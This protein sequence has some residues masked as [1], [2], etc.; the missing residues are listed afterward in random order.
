MSVQGSIRTDPARRV[1]PKPRKA[2][3]AGHEFPTLGPSS[4][5]A[6]E[7]SKNVHFAT[8]PYARVIL[9]ERGVKPSGGPFHA[10]TMGTAFTA[11]GLN[12]SSWEKLWEVPFSASLSPVC[13]ACSRL[14][15]YGAA[16][17]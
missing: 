11:C 4:N 7:V 16:P 3:S 10:K 14:V 12:S 5:E 15:T 2:R 6:T 8:A 1:P 17:R 9:T 13:P